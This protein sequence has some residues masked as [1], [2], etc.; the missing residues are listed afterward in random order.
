M[1]KYICLLVN[2]SIEENPVDLHCLSKRLQN[3]STDGE[4]RQLVVIGPLRVNKCEFSIYTVMI[5][6]IYTCVCA[7]Q[8]TY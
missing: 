7:E 4:S 5:I 2:I 8:T 1:P 3:I 6:M